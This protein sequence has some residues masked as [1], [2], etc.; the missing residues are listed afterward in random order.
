[1]VLL[2]IVT[3]EAGRFAQS[4]APHGAEYRALIDAVIT[5]HRS[6][7]FEDVSDRRL[8]QTGVKPGASFGSF[9][10]PDA[11]G[12]RIEPVFHNGR[13]DAFSLSVKT[14]DPAQCRTLVA[15]QDRRVVRMRV[16]GE[17]VREGAELPSGFALLGMCAGNSTVTLEVSPSWDGAVKG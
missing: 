12:L 10:F 13:P 5:S 9:V 3:F 4:P 7:T 6:G 17:V 8:G 14:P 16:N 11:D 2:G 1:M 15:L